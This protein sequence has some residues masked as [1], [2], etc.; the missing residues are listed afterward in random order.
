MGFENLAVGLIGLEP[1][2]LRQ[3]DQSEDPAH[4]S[5]TPRSDIA[6]SVPS[7]SGII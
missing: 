7:R 5:L 3:L 4:R 2:L 1:E 6:H